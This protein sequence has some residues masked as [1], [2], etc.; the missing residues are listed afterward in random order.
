[1]RSKCQ[2]NRTW[3]TCSLKPLQQPF[4]RCG[5][6][7]SRGRSPPRGRDGGGS[8]SPQGPSDPATRV[9]SLC[10]K[11]SACAPASKRRRE[12]RVGATHPAGWF[13]GP[14]RPPEP[15]AGCRRWPGPRRSP[16][17]HWALKVQPHLRVPF[18][19]PDSLHPRVPKL[20]LTLRTILHGWRQGFKSSNKGPQWG[21]RG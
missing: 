4:P 16:D 21:L 7:W 15:T 12:A 11:G 19:L 9:I 10:A 5:V 13:L 18:H 3:F 20:M 1:M 6:I 14:A 2:G 17:P 8:P